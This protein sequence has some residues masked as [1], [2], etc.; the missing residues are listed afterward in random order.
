MQA[1]QLFAEN[2]CSLKVDGQPVLGDLMWR[3]LR[4]KIKT[5]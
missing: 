3:R 5:D 2:S 1:D 4:L